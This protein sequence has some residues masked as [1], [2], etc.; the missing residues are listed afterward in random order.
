MMEPKQQFFRTSLQVCE[1]VAHWRMV[2]THGVAARLRAV[3]SQ[4]SLVGTMVI[5]RIPIGLRFS[6]PPGSGAIVMS[7]P[8]D[9]MKTKRRHVI[10]HSLM[11]FKHEAGDSPYRLGIAGQCHLCPF[12]SNLPWSE[13]VIPRQ[14][15]KTVPVRLAKVMS[16]PIAIRTGV[17]HSRDARQTLAI[18]AAIQHLADS[19]AAPLRVSVGVEYL[20]PHLRQ[21]DES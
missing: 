11:R 17:R 2:L 18:K 9:V 19:R 5:D 3:E 6:V 21:K 10:D 20:A 15:A 7:A 1:M 12:F 14:P 13:I 4:P 16:S 8:H